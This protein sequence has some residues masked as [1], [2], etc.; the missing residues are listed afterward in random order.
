VINNIRLTMIEATGFSNQAHHI[1]L[2]GESM[3]KHI[4]KT[5]ISLGETY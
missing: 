2:S 3:R 5:I 4:N 1:E